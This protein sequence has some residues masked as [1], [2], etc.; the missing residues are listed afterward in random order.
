MEAE[1][2]KHGTDSWR[3]SKKGREENEGHSK[4]GNIMS[5]SGCWRGTGQ[6]CGILKRTDE[7]ECK[8]QFL[9]KIAGRSVL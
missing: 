6:I 1:R 2:R 4:Q 5:E 7:P 9:K 8:F 3:E